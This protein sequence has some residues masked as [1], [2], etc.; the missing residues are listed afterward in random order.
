MKRRFPVVS[1]IV[2]LSFGLA[3]AVAAQTATTVAV[4]LAGTVFGLPESVYFSGTAQI[5]VRPAEDTAP[6]AKPRL[7]VSIDLGDVSG[8]GLST[9]ATYTVNGQASLTRRFTPS[10]TVQ[11]TFPFFVRGAV[12]TAQARTAVASFTFSYD[13]ATGALTAANAF[14]AAPTPG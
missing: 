14:L 13:P 4:P 10:D 11:L 8:R 2:S 9:G 7:I 5:S 12:A 3:T 6:G 1:A